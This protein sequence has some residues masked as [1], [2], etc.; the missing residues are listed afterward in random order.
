MAESK[1]TSTNTSGEVRRPAAE[2]LYGLRPAVVRAV[3]EALDSG[4][5]ERVRHLI[6]PLHFSDVADLLERL[7]PEARRH[8]IDLLRDWLAPEV[9][10]ELDEAVREEIME[11][12]SAEEVA[13]AVTGLDTDDAVE[14]I[15]DLDEDVRQ[16]VL[17][18]IPAEERALLQEG[19]AYPEESAGRMM[20]RETVAV[21]SYWTVGE[22]I[23]HMRETQDLPDDFYDIFVVDPAHRPVGTLALNR[24]L[25]TRRPVRV[26][27]IMRKDIER[28]PVDSDQEDLA[29]LFRQHDLVS[30]PV[31]DEGGRLVGM[32]TV[33]DVVDVIDEE[34]EE[35]LMRLGGVTEDDLYRAAIATTQARFSW[36]GV[37]L[38]TAIIASVVIGL[39]E[40]TL[41]QIVALA[42]L[43]PIVASMG[44]NAGTQTMTVAV[45]ALAMRELT[46]SNAARF[47]GKE[48]LVGGINGILFAV[49]VALVATAWFS[50]ARLGA[51]I[52]AAMITNLVVAGLAG[53]L[54]PLGL[55]NRGIDP[56]IASG[57]LLT[58]VT[59]VI[60]F[61]AFLGLAAL[62]LL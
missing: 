22:T 54:I 48:L 41:D 53:T 42:V 6:G 25:R 14:V 30:A 8:A 61:V 24:L 60:G 12:L 40:A 18:A 20:Q 56:A 19:L 62:F 32:I 9:L 7:G 50:D 3:T 52:G 10:T 43:M 36:L 13:A 55:A 17:D 23:D 44:G 34:A 57:V 51:V 35:D 29:I 45:R 15:E 38:I 33:D 5:G 37:N 46:S 11:R 4:D 59:D 39:F 26:A 47:I 49:L 21:P 16:Q 2:A 27:E 31:V 1:Q 28:I 58:T